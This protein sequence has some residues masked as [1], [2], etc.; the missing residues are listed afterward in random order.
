VTS[1]FF[2]IGKSTRC[3]FSFLFF[4]LSDL[5]AEYVSPGDCSYGDG[6]GE[7][8]WFFSLF[9][10]ADCIERPLFSSST[11]LCIPFAGDWISLFSFLAKDGK[12]LFAGDNTA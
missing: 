10:P 12:A 11:R 2:G 8:L 9:L 3:S 4:P 6:I 1:L 7:F 5:R